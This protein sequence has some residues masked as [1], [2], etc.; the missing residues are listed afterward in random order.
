MCDERLRDERPLD[1]DEIA[2]RRLVDRYLMGRLDDDEARRFERHY[3]SCD[4]CLAELETTEELVG[5]LR[6]VAAEDAARGAVALGLLA[7]LTRLGRAGRAAFVAAVLAAVLA[8]SALLYRELGDTRRELAATRA[9]QAAAA[10]LPLNPQRGEGDEPSRVIRLG[11][12]P[13]W[14]VLALELDR[15]EHAAYRVVLRDAS[16]TE[17][18]RGDGLAPDLRDT[19]TVTVHGS[20]LAAGVYAL[21]VAGLPVAGLPESRPVARFSFRVE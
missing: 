15:P 9:P 12:A 4:T 7:R 14:V 18:W 2:E 1:H 21:E 5:G 20:T 10:V 6:D 8:P 17:L 13:G 16:G 19:L 11:D 3:L